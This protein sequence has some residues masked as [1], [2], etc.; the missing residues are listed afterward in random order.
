MPTIP[1]RTILVHSDMA[2]QDMSDADG[3]DD[4]LNEEDLSATLQGSPPPCDSK[5]KDSSVPILG[6]DVMDAPTVSN[7]DPP[8]EWSIERILAVLQDNG[9]PLI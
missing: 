6:D 5:S 9:V 3:S 1:V 7:L 2:D 4:T 8:E